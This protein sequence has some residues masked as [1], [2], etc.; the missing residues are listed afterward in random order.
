VC[1]VNRHIQGNLL[2]ASLL[3]LIIIM[4]LMPMMLMPF[5]AAGPQRLTDPAGPARQA[6]AGAQHTPGHNRS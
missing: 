4:M 6:A 3:L 1:S 2:E 5:M